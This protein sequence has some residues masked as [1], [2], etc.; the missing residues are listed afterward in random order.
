MAACH[1]HPPEHLV[2]QKTKQDAEDT[3]TGSAGRV[4][5]CKGHPRPSQ[6][7]LSFP[8]S[9]V[10][11]GK[12][13]LI[14]A[15][16]AV[17]VIPSQSADQATHHRASDLRC[18]PQLTVTATVALMHELPGQQVQGPDDLRA[19]CPQLTVT[20]MVAL[21]HELSEQVQQTGRA[22]SLMGLCAHASP[23]RMLLPSFRS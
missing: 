9:G 23:S 3:R 13:H 4:A 7:S 16:T 11:K 17:S 1:L 19:C 20:A 15:L 12:G 5:N 10:A 2:C 21:M 8:V 18:C 14:A 22:R 6:R